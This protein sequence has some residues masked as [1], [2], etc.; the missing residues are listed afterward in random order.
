MVGSDE[1][2]RKVMV[3]HFHT[4]AVG[5][6]SGVQATLKRINSFFYWKGLK[7][8]VKE[9]V[10]TCDVC[11]RI[12]ADLSSYPGLLQPLPIPTQIWQDI[13]MDFIDSLSVSQGKSTILV[14]VDRLSKYAHFIAVTHPYTAK[15][16]AQ[17]FL[18]HIYKL[19]GL[20]KTIVSDRDTVFMSLF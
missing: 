8:M 2:L 11:Q 17:L 6:H 13:S 10:R 19:H 15:N 7:K 9:T 4:S 16:I 1:N 3:V 18:D 20:P 14:V 5:G 12:K